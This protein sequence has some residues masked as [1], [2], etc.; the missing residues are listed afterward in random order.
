MAA[1]ATLDFEKP[2]VELEQKVAA[3]RVLVEAGHAS[4]RDLR[5]R[6]EEL[7]RFRRKVIQRL[8]RWQKVQLAR[9][10]D[11]P[12]A[13][14]YLQGMLEE[15]VEIHGDRM[16]HEDAAVMGGLGRLDGI[17]V[18]V[19]GHEK[20][21]T[22][23]QRGQRRFGMPHPEGNRK[24]LRLMSLAERFGRPVLTLV[25]TPGAYPGVE[26]EARG[27]AAAIAENLM[28]LATL[29]TPSLSVIIGEGGSGGALALAL[30]DR[31]LMMEHAVYSVISPEGCAAILW[32]DE[33]KKAQAAE[34]LRVTAQD[35]LAMGLIQDI[36]PEPPGGAH[37]DEQGAIRALKEACHLHL[38]ELLQMS[39][40]DL[41]AQR[42]RRY[43]GM[44][45]VEG[46]PGGEDG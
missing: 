31:V 46:E 22:I 10:M 27:Q 15:F 3:L 12:H 7:D 28:R 5:R 9:H 43:R 21:R 8:N 20:G 24:A 29:K 32:R 6:E 30:A 44:G 25:D 14:D 17:P 39:L 16:G 40:K 13:V 4:A 23:Q 41:L 19:I 11:R 1:M 45:V 18:V 2:I 33:G 42:Y 35:A 34:A 38:K 37:R 36:V 26:A